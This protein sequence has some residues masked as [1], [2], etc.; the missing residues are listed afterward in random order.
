M[1]PR[2]SRSGSTN[3][4]G[5]AEC[6]SAL[7]AA[8]ALLCVITCCLFPGEGYEIILPGH[9]A[10]LGRGC[11]PEPRSRKVRRCRSTAPTPRRFGAPGV[12]VGRREGGRPACGGRDTLAPKETDSRPGSGHRRNQKP[13][14]PAARGLH[15]AQVPAE[16]VIAQVLPSTGADSS[17]ATTA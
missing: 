10:R 9:S 3:S 5:S 2:S 15:E 17:S 12:R 11:G 6:V 14:I 16:R 13:P 7:N 4:P 8:M 1:N